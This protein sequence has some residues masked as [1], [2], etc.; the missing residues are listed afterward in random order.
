M[1]LHL[2]SREYQAV[3]FDPARFSITL[4]NCRVRRDDDRLKLY[5]DIHFLQSF[6]L[7]EFLFIYFN[8]FSKN[9]QH[10]HPQLDFFS[11]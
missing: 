6:N 7:H 3:S 5:I 1:Q 2:K 11:K 9:P 4:E 8:I 10:A